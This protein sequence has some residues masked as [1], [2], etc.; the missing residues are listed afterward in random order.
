MKS[1]VHEDVSKVLSEMEAE[2]IRAISPDAVTM[3]V[4]D[5]F[6][7]HD[8]QDARYQVAMID[9]V[10]R[11]VSNMFNRYKVKAEVDEEVDTQLVLP[12]YERLQQRYLIHE[13]GQS[14]AVRT[15]ELTDEQ[16]ITKQSELRNMGAGCFKHA[17]EIGR[18][19][20]ERRVESVG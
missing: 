19:M 14:F 18:Y 2:G 10:R 12:G 8:Q 11:T 13:N 4:I 20:E 17:D 6:G 3:N 1:T 9:H 7:V 15:D 5:S 16:L